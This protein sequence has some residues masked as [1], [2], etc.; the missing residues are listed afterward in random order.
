MDADKTLAGSAR[1]Y[2]LRNLTNHRRADHMRTPIYALTI[3]ALMTF[4]KIAF[5][6]GSGG[7]PTPSESKRSAVR[8]NIPPAQH[9]VV[10]NQA[11]PMMDISIEGQTVILK[12]TDADG[13]PIDTE[14]AD[15]KTFITTRGEISTLFLW[16]AGGNVLSGTGDFSPD[17]DLRIEVKLNLPDSEPFR[18]DF[19]PLK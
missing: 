6:H 13:N 11:Q 19:Y 9:E 8:F 18:K 10:S 14:F 16:P 12:I 3:L 1:C 5:A 7:A 17:P 4:G 15:A 2:S